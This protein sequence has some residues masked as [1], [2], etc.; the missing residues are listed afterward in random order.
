LTF[1]SGWRLPTSSPER[2]NSPRWASS[3]A[4][5]AVA[6]WPFRPLASEPVG[7]LRLAGVPKAVQV[8]FAPMAATACRW[9][10][11]GAI[12][13]VRLSRSSERLDSRWKSGAVTV[14]VGAALAPEMVPIEARTR[15]ASKPRISRVVPRLLAARDR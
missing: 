3:Q 9:A 14:L 15:A 1:S 10:W 5:A 7:R 11:V 13:P 6:A 4:S 12:A 2:L 8:A